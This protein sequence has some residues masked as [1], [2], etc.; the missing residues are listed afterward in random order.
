MGLLA[1]AIGWH[2]VNNQTTNFWIDAIPYLFFNTSLYFYT[3]LPDIHGDRKTNKQTLAVLKGK[4]VVINISTI[5]YC[6]ALISA[7][8]FK[9]FFALFF[10]ILTF[11][12]II[13]SFIKK[14]IAVTIIATKYAI[15]FFAAAICLKVPYFFIILISIFIITKWYFNIR[16]QYNYPNFKGE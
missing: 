8:I 11:P 7:Y 4:K 16:F 6:G 9:D 15:F 12:F 13:F 3:L 10:M 5:C 14:D 1:L 2:S